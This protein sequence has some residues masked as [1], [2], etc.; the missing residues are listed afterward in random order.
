MITRA[1]P[2]AGMNGCTSSGSAALSNTSRQRSPSISSRRRTARAA[3]S[4]SGWLTPSSAATSAR[5]ARIPPRSPALI[6]ATS[7]HRSASLARA[8]AAARCVLPTPRSPV[9]ACTTTTRDPGPGASSAASR[10][11]LGWK[12]SGSRGISPTMTGASYRYQQA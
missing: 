9:N 4:A 8:Y 11:V 1:V 7:R 3:P 10:S 12:P 5:P 2:I 6:Q